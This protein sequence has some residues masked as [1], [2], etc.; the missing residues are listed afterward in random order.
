M[1]LPFC[2]SH[3]F[4][5]YN[6]EIPAY[7]VIGWQTKLCF[8]VYL[9]ISQG[10]LFIPDISVYSHVNIS[11]HMYSKECTNISKCIHTLPYINIFQ[12]SLI[13]LINHK[14][15]YTCTSLNIKD[16]LIRGTEIN[17]V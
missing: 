3:H 15:V 9:E 10:P 5:N 1:R 4:V 7:P 11:I 17:K 6:I 16:C 8:L 14:S 12:I 2:H 13:S